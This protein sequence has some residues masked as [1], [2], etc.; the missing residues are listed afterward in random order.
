VQAKRY[1]EYAPI[2]TLFTINR[3][4]G[5][6]PVLITKP[7]DGLAVACLP[8]MDF[9]RLVASAQ[10]KDLRNPSAEDFV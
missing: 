9:L 5:S 3:P 1:K 8:L 2:S 10:S 6:V 4:L 7:D